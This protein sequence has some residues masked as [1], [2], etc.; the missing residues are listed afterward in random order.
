MDIFR[1]ISY[2]DVYGDTRLGGAYGHADDSQVYESYI[3]S[4]VYSGSTS[5][6]DTFIGGVV[7]ELYTDFNLSEH[8]M[9][10][11]RVNAVVDIDA[12]IV[13]CSDADCGIV[14][15][16]V[17]SSHASA[18]SFASIAEGFIHD[19]VRTTDSQHSFT[20]C[21]SLQGTTCPA[22]LG[23]LSRDYG[24]ELDTV[25]CSNLSGASP[26]L[27]FVDVSGTCK[28]LFAKRWDE[29]GFDSSQTG[30]DYIGGFIGRLQSHSSNQS[31]LDV[32]DSFVVLDKSCTNKVSNLN[33]IN[34][35]GGSN[36]GGIVGA[37][38]LTSNSKFEI[39][40]TYVDTS[41]AKL[42]GDYGHV[43]RII[44]G[45]RNGNHYLQDFAIIWN[46]TTNGSASSSYH[47]FSNSS[48]L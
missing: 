36:I 12:D 6:S 31:Y 29:F 22:T 24:S 7:G 5:S 28:P 15:G 27:P 39:E 40:K 20:T 42:P 8:F 48:D 33:A 34:A 38:D 17:T 35:S 21:G 30:N 26:P 47:Y 9:S 41:T 19:D 4:L 14:V 46:A 45:T 2:V 32:R 37:V 3:D 13:D 25:I 1:S 10:T 23:G 44:A 43:G 18:I 11:S 16:G